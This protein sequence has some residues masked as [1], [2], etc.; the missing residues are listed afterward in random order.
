MAVNRVTERRRIQ[1]RSG[2]ER[3]TEL[4]WEGWL[5]GRRQGRG[6]RLEDQLGIIAR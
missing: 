3:R 1:R 4:R 2:V 5:K 6:R